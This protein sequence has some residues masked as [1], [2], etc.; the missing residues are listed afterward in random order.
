LLNK[1]FVASISL[2]RLTQKEAKEFVIKRWNPIRE[3]D[4]PRCFLWFNWGNESE[5]KAVGYSRP[6]ETKQ[7]G[8]HNN[9]LKL[10]TMRWI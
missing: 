10:V 4:S 1:Y 7:F 5:K 9:S 6:G 2:E 3:P 8:N